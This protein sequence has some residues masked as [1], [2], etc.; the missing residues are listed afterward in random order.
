[1][2][3]KHIMNTW[4]VYK[5]SL[6]WRAKYQDIGSTMEHRPGHGGGVAGREGRRVAPPLRVEE[7]LPYHL[8]SNYYLISSIMFFF[9]TKNTVNFLLNKRNLKILYNVRMLEN[10]YR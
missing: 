2:L 5:L 9:T 7:L 6:Y 3:Y 4:L 10:I 1:M 8:I